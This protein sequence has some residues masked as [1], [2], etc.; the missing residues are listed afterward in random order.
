LK[1]IRTYFLY[2]TDYL[3]HGDWE[4][5]IASVKYVLN[6][7]SHGSDRIIKTS[8]GKFFCRKNTNDFQFANLYY[9]WGVRKFIL[10]HKNEFSVFIDG[11]ACI[12]DYCIWLAGMDKR[13]FAFELVADNVS[14]FE[15]NIQL[16][17]LQDKITV[18]PF[19]LGDSDYVAGFNFDPVNTGASRINKVKTSG[20]N[21]SQIRKLDSFMET[22]KI[23]KDE[24]IYFK[25]DVE[26]M[27]TEA[28]KGAYDFIMYYPNITLIVE[29]KHSGQL[30]I[31][32]TLSDIALFEFGK[33]DELNIYAKK[34]RNI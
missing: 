8:I 19:G 4:S 15:K 2:L 25:L 13:C 30:P 16:N 24:H 22:M 12:G 10:K 18:F 3:K 7:S 9:E 28:I 11:G 33:V 27:E 23:S 31:Q 32:D 5:V 34:I 1:K 14:T 6:K 20:E 29:E 21:V 17:D 26:G